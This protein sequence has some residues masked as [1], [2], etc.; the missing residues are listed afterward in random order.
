MRSTIAYFFSTPSA[1]NTRIPIPILIRI[2][3]TIVFVGISLALAQ[4][5]ELRT[6]QRVEN[7]INRLINNNKMHRHQ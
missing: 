7:Q 6:N 1:Q 4:R 2:P 5:E 3:H